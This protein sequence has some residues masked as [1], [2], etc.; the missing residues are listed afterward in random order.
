MLDEMISIATAASD[1]IQIVEAIIKRYGHRRVCEIGVWKGEFSRK[2]LDGCPCVES[3]YMIDPWKKLEEWNKPFNVKDSAFEDVY[4]EAM[5]NIDGWLDRCV[6]LRGR[7]TDVIENIEDGSLDLI[8][9]DGDHTLR[10]ISVDLIASFAKLRD[11]G[12]IVGDDFSP[13]IWQHSKEF[14]PTLV[15]PFAI[16]FAEAHRLPIFAMPFNQ[17][18]IPKVKDSGFRFSDLTSRYPTTALLD[19]LTSDYK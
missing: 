16:H 13:T 17:F 4:D 1:R 8:Y 14:E 11:G 10:G 9:I 18:V 2:I 6:V 3:Y 7:T 12:V 19:Q 5:R 15:F